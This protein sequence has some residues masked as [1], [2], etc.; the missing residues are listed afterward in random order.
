[1]ACVYTAPHTTPAVEP[2]LT[3]VAYDA[4]KRR[5]LAGDY[6][7]G[8]RLAEV[9]LAEQLGVSRTPVREALARLHA[10]GFVVRLPEGGYSP[11]APDLHT[12]A[13][14]YVVRRGLERTAL[15]NEQG[16]DMGL[17][18]A[19]RDDWA[20][21]DNVPDEPDPDFVLHDEDYHI[22]LAEASGNRSLAEILARVSERIRIVR[23]QDFLSPDRI[24]KTVTEHL[25]IVDALIEGDRE[26]ADRRLVRH[27]AISRR[28][29]E[30]RS[31]VALSRMVN[32]GRDG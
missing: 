19:L 18:Q 6:P 14:L 30:R 5:L 9:A 16:H 11:A 3:S 10:E 32:G 20:S 24:R 4:L 7:I 29:V 28:V 15:H 22:R 31:A 27:L 12:I 23:I 17:L 2:S 21:F 25:S 26:L 1:M 8:R 13:E